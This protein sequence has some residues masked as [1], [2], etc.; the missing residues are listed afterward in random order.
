MRGSIRNSAVGGE[1]GIARTLRHILLAALIVVVAP[2]L[3]AAASGGEP[4]ADNPRLAS[5]QIEIWPEYDRPAALV[6]LKGE[7]PEEV[8]LPA[9]VSLRLAT[10]TG[11]PLAV[12]YA[13]LSGDVL[14][15]LDYEREDSPGF[16][17]LK[18]K[19][20]GRVFH[21]EF[22][23]PLNTATLQRAYT[24][25]WPGDF[26]TDRLTV[27][28]QEP[29]GAIDLSAT[30]ALDSSV[31]GSDGLRYRSG[32]LGAFEAATRFAVQIAYT[33]TNPRT[34]AEILRAQPIGAAAGASS[35]PWMNDN[36]WSEVWAISA[37]FALVLAV[38]LGVAGLAWRRRRRPSAAAR[39]GSGS[40]CTRCG[41]PATAGDHFCAKCGAGLR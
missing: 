28:V 23:E 24:Y 7:L 33:K 21:V 30:P 3:A 39:P 14:R 5:L 22:Y 32:Q 38:A 4:F 36:E 16:I 25:V 12:A 35:A 40:F 37:L 9:P 20:P 10:A 29:V 19:V 31:M 41:A 15:N 26:A 27:V 8:V 11:G 18:L 2:G 13:N 17:T 6:I 34:S 1:V